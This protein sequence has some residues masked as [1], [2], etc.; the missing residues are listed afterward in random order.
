M[1]SA[2]RQDSFKN[3]VKHFLTLLTL[4]KVKVLIFI[5]FKLEIFTHMNYAYTYT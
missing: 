1:R 4:N 3:R 5:L 2:D